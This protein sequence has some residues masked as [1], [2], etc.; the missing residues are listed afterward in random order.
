MKE[1]F[2]QKKNQLKNHFHK[3]SP[4]LEEIFGQKKNKLKTIY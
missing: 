4:I 1:I 2:G 3:S